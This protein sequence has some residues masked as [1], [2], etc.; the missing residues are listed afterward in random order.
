MPYA[1]GQTALL[2]AAIASQRGQREHAIS[3]TEKAA[4]AF[5]EAGLDL[6]V[7]YTRRRRAQLVGSSVDLAEADA[8][9]RARGVADP[10]RWTESQAPG[11]VFERT[12][13]DDAVT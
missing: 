3:A 10:A 6:E 9:L 8:A 5:A 12:G 2:H 1:R 13:N 4:A 7:A 11:F